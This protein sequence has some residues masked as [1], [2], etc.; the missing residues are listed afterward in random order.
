MD[1]G[2]KGAEKV[3]EEGRGNGTE[4]E[5]KGTREMAGKVEGQGE[6]RAGGK[7]GKEEETERVATGKGGRE[8]D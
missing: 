1:Q 3:R 8:R 7:R 2:R 5:R 4:R 6:E